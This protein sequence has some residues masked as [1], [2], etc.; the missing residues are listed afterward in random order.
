MNST[1]YTNMLSNHPDMVQAVPAMP[2]DNAAWSGSNSLGN[3][4]DY[5]PDTD[6]RQMILKL[7]EWGPPEM[8]TVSLGIDRPAP[9]NSGEAHWFEIKAL[10]DFGVGG[11]TQ[12]IE[13]DWI[14]GTELT[15]PMN[16]ISVNAVYENPTSLLEGM[17]LSVQIAR[18][19]RAGAYAPTRMLDFEA[20][21]TL[22][23]PSPLVTSLY[24][25]LRLPPFT[26]EIEIIWWDA[27]TNPFASVPVPPAVLSPSRLI[28]GDVISPDIITSQLRCPSSWID[29]RAITTN[30]QRYS[31]PKGSRYLSLREVSP[32]DGG[33][34]VANAFRVNCHLHG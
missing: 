34:F 30:A 29:L 8:W 5:A 2:M 10:I 31:V 22:T 9:G 17:R 7:D 3:V 15:V 16:A 6:N 25:T 11:S 18:G 24:Q 26:R 33:P 19:T 1:R 14:N 20:M 32:T 27:Y 12:R 4:V 28:F 21:S 13:V 23:L